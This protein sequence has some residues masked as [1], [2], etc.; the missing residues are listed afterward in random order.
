MEARMCPDGS[1]VGRT[2]PNCE[3]T[4]CGAIP[5]PVPPT[6]TSDFCAALFVGTPR[7][8]QK[9][10][11]VTNLQR[12]LFAIYNPSMNPTGYFGSLTRSYILKFQKDNGI[13]QVGL[14][15]PVTR[16]ALKR[17]CDANY[18]S[19]HTPTS[20]IPSASC[21]VWFDGCNTCSRSTVGGPLACTQMACI[22]AN[23][24]AA[25]CRESF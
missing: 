14:V 2:G 7:F 11:S 15:G 12:Y 13:A 6:S 25:T 1:Y 9:S 18:A 21:K 23:S 24:D 4:P 19:V 17:T 5:T 3:F 8:G 20:D 10:S 22:W 16:A